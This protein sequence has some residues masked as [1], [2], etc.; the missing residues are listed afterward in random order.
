[1]NEFL[2]MGGYAAY[3]WPAYGVT[4]LTGLALG[5]HSLRRYRRTRELVHRLERERARRGGAPVE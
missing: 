3:V 1:M 5:L 2:A 4:L